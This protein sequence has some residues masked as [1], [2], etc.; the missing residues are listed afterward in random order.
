MCHISRIFFPRDSY[1][2]LGANLVIGGE[3]QE[4]KS[5]MLR[6]SWDQGLTVI[7]SCHPLLI[8]EFLN[9]SEKKGTISVFS[10][11]EKPKE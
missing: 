4:H 10:H 6:F 11:S 5:V 7:N 2:L 9:S 8:D 1:G 3:I